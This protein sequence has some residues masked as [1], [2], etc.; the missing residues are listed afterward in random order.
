MG[1]EDNFFEL[2]GDSIVSI[3]LV[4]RARR[5]G[6]S[7]TPRAVFQ[8]QTVEALAAAAVRRQRLAG[9]EG[10]AQADAAR[11]AVG[12]LPLTPIMRWLK[13]RGGPLGRFSQS[14]L[15]R[16]PGGLRQEHLAAALDALLGH[17]DALR[18]RLERS[19]ADGDWNLEI[20]PPGTVAG[21][22]CLRR[23]D[24]VG[25]ED[26][27]LRGLIAEAAEAA[28]GRLDPAAGVMVQ[29]LWFDAGAER[30]GRLWLCIHHLA[31]DGV[32]WRILVPDLVA[33]WQAIAAGQAVALPPRGTPFR[34]WARRLAGHARDESVAAE[35]SYWSGAAGQPSL[36]LVQER[37]DPVRDTHGTAGHLRVMLPAAV[38]QALLT[39][40]PS[41]FHG[42]IDDVLLTGLSV[43][44]ADWCRRHVGAGMSGRGE[45]SAAASHAVLLDLEGHGREEAFGREEVFGRE[46]GLGREGGGDIDLTR[47]VGWFTSL[48]PVRLDPGP[49]DLEDALAGGAALGRALKTIK[50]QLRAVPGKGLGYGLLRYLNGDTAG[51]LGGLP[52]PQL[53]FNY[54]GRFADGG[55]EA[56]WAPAPLAAS[57]DESL[58]ESEEEAFAAR[59]GGGDPAMPLSHVIEVNA[60]TLDGADGPRLTANWSW[61][62][63]SNS[64]RFFFFLLAAFG[65]LRP[66][67]PRHRR[68]ATA[69]CCA[70][71]SNATPAPTNATFARCAPACTPSAATCSARRC[72]ASAPTTR[73]ASTTSPTSIGS[74]ATMGHR[75]GCV[76]APEAETQGVNDRWQLALAERELRNRTNRTWLLNGVTM[77]DPRQTFVDVTVQLGRDVTLY[78]GTI[79][80]GN[81]VGRR[82]LRDRPRHT[83][84]R[85]PVGDGAVVRAHRRPRQR[86]RR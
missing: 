8:H 80:Q 58:D 74:L 55:A 85:L 66:R 44:V 26:A 1:V 5:A 19:A 57:L 50:E 49:L 4:S 54:L 6:L 9:R 78:P 18:L 68:P 70:S 67:H 32:S 63:A 81:T 27:S 76:Q 65:M 41:A 73:R 23:I 47:T 13:E 53:G 2:G 46:E 24:A 7:I 77:L 83:A 11:L 22:A 62:G 52:A 51:P 17:H 29:A 20:A 15:L 69:A 30:P 64:R 45:G 34:L 42:G 37:L 12:G 59:A 39:R 21:A 71:S 33:A 84:H 25:I 40:V 56:D 72:A 14:M 86:G 3:Q 61:A 10:L 36:L 35:L 60:L 75:V 48:Y 16:V 28:E 31:V 38:T 43:A 82:R 79:L